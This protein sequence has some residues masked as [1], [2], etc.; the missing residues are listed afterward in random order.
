MITTDCINCDVKRDPTSLMCREPILC[1]SV[2][3]VRGVCGIPEIKW[4]WGVRCYIAEL[5]KVEKFFGRPRCRV[6]YEDQSGAPRLTSTDGKQI[7][8]AC[9]LGS[10]GRSLVL[11]V[12]RR[13][14]Q[15]S[16]EM[17]VKD[18]R[19]STLSSSDTQLFA[20]SA[21]LLAL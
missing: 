10:C 9:W 2:D 7:L 21:W 5:S 18:Q 3:R 15:D 1:A 4:S 19:L 12:S 11:G 13:L 8:N 17:L 14:A 6:K 20:P 16:T